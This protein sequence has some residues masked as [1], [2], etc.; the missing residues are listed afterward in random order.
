ME[1]QIYKEC[2]ES[3]KFRRALGGSAMMCLF[4]V[5]VCAGFLTFRHLNPVDL[6]PVEVDVRHACAHAECR[7][8]HKQLER[9]TEYAPSAVVILTI[10]YCGIVGGTVFTSTME[11]S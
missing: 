11:G 7:S 8:G 1:E 5:L 9:E 4:G 2:R 6:S 3:A 10:L